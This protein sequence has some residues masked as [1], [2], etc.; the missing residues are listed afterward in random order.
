MPLTKS[1][2]RATLLLL[3]IAIGVVASVWYD[4]RNKQAESQGDVQ[5]GA[6]TQKPDTAAAQ[7]I[8]VAAAGDIV[9]EMT[10]FD[11]NTVDSATLVRLGLHPRQ[12]RSFIRYR[13]AGAVFSQ[14][15]D[16][17][18]V[19]ALDDDDIDRM[20]PYIVIADKYRHRRTK[21]PIGARHDTPQS[22]RTEPMNTLAAHHSNKFT[23]PTKVD[24]NRADTALLQRIPGI[25]PNIAT[26]IVRHRTRLGGFHTLDQLLEV[27]YVSPDMLQWFTLQPDSLQHINLNTT[28]FGRLSSHPY[29]GNARAKAISNRLRLYGPF[30]DADAVAATGLFTADTLALL[31]PYL[32]F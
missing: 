22:V 28:S 19:Y 31:L 4:S 23:S 3:V 15:E 10:T 14:P 11:P 5:A 30:P 17:E 20:L 27:Q 24:I 1:D 2:R 8:A 32:E 18:K 6:V 26:W 9:V 29:I 16:I 7:S 21:Y 12:A 13:N 25:G